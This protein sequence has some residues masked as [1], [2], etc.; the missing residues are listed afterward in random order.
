MEKS[1]IG[2]EMGSTKLTDVAEIN[3]VASQSI[4]KMRVALRTKSMKI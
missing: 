4:C 2:I 1:D 3:S